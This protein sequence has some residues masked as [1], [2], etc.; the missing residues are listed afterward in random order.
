M[1]ENF[2]SILLCLFF[3]LV[4]MEDVINIVFWYVVSEVVRLDVFF[5]E[6]INIE[7]YCYFEGIYSV[8]GCLIFSDDE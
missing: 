5:I 7:S 2:W 1:K 3:I 6:F 8:C 4:F